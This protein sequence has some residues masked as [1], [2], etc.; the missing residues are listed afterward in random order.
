MF[1]LVGIVLCIFGVFSD[2]INGMDLCLEFWYNGGIRFLILIIVVCNWGFNELYYF[3]LNLESFKL[4][5]W[6]I[7]L[8]I[9]EL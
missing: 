3:V 6:Y 1:D 7:S 5:V 2:V 4:I 8:L 9:Y